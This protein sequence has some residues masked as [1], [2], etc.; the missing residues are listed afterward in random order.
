MNQRAKGTIEGIVQ[1]VGFRPFLY[2]LAGRYGLTG[3]VANTSS[4]VDVEV[5]GSSEKVHAF[6]QA[7]SFESPPLARIAAVTWKTIPPKKDRHFNIISSRAGKE[8]NA[9]I[10][11]DVCVC[12]QCLEEMMNPRD[13]RY[14][15]PF[16]NCT[17][18]GPR[19]TIIKDVPYDR[20]VTTMQP[21][22]M[23]SLCR[24][25][26]DDPNSR[27]FHAQPNACWNCGPFLA[28]HGNR[29]ERLLC[30][31]PVQKTIEL[32]SQ[33]HILAIKGLGGFH[34]AVD[35]ANHKAVVRLRK[36]KHREEKPL[37]VMAK[38]LEGARRIAHV[39][40]LEA[41]LLVSRQRPIVLLKKKRIHGLSP[42]VAPGNR[43]V[44][45]MLPYTPLHFLLMEGPF[46]A[47]VMTSGNLSEEPICID[48]GEAFERLAHIADYFLVH[49][50]GIHLRSDDSVLRVVSRV[51]RQI[52]R[53]RGFVPEPIFLP[54]ILK[55]MPSVLGVGGELKNTVCLTKENRAFLSQHIGDMENMETL[56]FFE[57][58]ID[59]LRNIL[60]IRPSVIGCDQH[61][62]YLSS[63]YAK[64]QTECPV[65]AIQ[66]HHAHIVSC[67]AE[68]GVFGP[69]IGLAMDGTGLGP[70]GAVWGG[71]VMT[72]DMVSFTRKAHLDYVPLPGGD[73]AA[74]EPW[75]MALAYLH[76]TFGDELFHLP[77]PLVQGL[78]REKARLVVQI[79]EK[80]IHSP[81]TSSCGRLFDA[82]SALLGIRKI[83][84]FEGQAAIELEMRI[85][86]GEK[87]RYSWQL[88]P[89]G[90]EILMVF[91][92]MIREMVDD[93]MKGT[94][95]GTISARFHNTLV[96]VLL[97]LCE[98]IRDET[99]IKDVALSGGVF[100]NVSLL[101]GLLGALEKSDFQVYAPSRAPASDGSLSLGQALCAGMTGAGF[102]GECEVSYEIRG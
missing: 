18:C 22:R 81:P 84:A 29:G 32:L 52:R 95:V 60:D 36:R 65:A 14:R 63:R 10:S 44:G 66:H 93:L 88:K 55:G 1:G 80:G 19:Y 59:H 3:H 62:D 9:L 16:I 35:A 41:D 37:A 91:D 25:E 53:S 82:V 31:D 21:F 83:I 39:N 38:D 94:P 69:V 28:L 90:S 49:N 70:D 20:D 75:R 54:E 89:N 26:Y 48:N 42:Q 58:T 96:A 15:Y 8:R 92:G 97:E 77:I 47:L 73:A 2:Q 34:L 68:N 86:P 100:Q 102:K 67:L 101:R 45:I 99:G 30:E 40:P 12:P 43:N 46:N 13:R 4:G 7:M 17:N 56:N 76:R 98:I 23:C 11:P 50:R 33:G 27:R 57:T 72:A 6:Q 24:E 5:E 78:D 74:R 85:R 71:E 61:P 79:A 51:P 87:G 64:N